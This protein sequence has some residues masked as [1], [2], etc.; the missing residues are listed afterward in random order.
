MTALEQLGA[1]VAT[2]VRGRVTADVQELLALHVTDTVAAWVA[3]SPT[4]EA[5]QLAKFRSSLPQSAGDPSHD[6]AVN[7]ATV[8]LSEVDDIHL[9][10]MITPGSIVV[11]AALLIAAT[12]PKT[13]AIALREAIALVD[14]SAVASIA[15]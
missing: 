9:A 2:G 11:P 12:M 4:S 14:R 10:A 7:C 6:I 13:D 1:F 15:A 8:R 3:A 5:Q